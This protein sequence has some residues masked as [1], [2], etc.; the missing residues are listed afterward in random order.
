[1]I[2]MRPWSKLISGSGD[3][4]DERLEQVWARVEGDTDRLESYFSDAQVRELPVSFIILI[5]LFHYCLALSLPTL[6]FNDLV[7]PQLVKQE[8]ESIHAIQEILKAYV[9]TYVV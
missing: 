6:Q 3:E 9:R 4:R 7:P 2:E 5:L 1:M 8:F